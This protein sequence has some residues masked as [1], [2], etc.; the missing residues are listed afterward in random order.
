MSQFH[1]A[2]VKRPRK[3]RTDGLCPCGERPKARPYRYCLPCK[4]A[5]MRAYRLRQ[6]ERQLRQIVD[7]FIAEGVA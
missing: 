1:A 4:A 6:R 7:R 2:T 5:W 3:P